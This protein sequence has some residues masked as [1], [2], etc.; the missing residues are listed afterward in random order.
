M[1]NW[2]PD[3]RSTHPRHSWLVQGPDQFHPLMFFGI[4]LTV[5][6]GGL[7]VIA[8]AGGDTIDPVGHDDTPLENRTVTASAAGR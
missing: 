2:L 6:K 7:A 8:R 1:D 5:R 4:A 3:W